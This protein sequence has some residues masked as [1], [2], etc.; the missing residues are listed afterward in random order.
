MVPHAVL[1]L[2]V[3]IGKKKQWGSRQKTS[4]GKVHV[5]DSSLH[6]HDFNVTFLEPLSLLSWIPEQTKSMKKITY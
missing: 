5:S 1:F 2:R 3:D 4:K 6:L